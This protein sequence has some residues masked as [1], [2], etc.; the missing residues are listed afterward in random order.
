MTHSCNTQTTTSQTASTNWTG[1]SRLFCSGWELDSTDLT[2]TY[3][4]SSR[5]ASL[6]CAHA[7]QISRLQNIFCNTIHYMRLWGG[8]CGLN[9]HYWRTSSM[10][11]WRNW[12]GQP[13]S[14]RQQASPSSIRRRRMTHS[15]KAMGDPCICRSQD[16]HLITM[17]VNEEMKNVNQVFSVFLSVLNLST[18]ILRQLTP[19]VSHPVENTN[20]Q[21][22]KKM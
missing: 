7:T 19:S 6:K 15:V 3:T 22:W 2:P 5:K 10:T 14:W 17:A 4:T 8:T 1:Q 16:Q 11:T 21:L 20:L 13:S 9:R 12:R 18:T